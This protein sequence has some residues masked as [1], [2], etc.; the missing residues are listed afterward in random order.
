M[1]SISRNRPNGATYSPGT[2]IVYSKYEKLMLE[3]VMW[4]YA[5]QELHDAMAGKLRAVFPT[6][7]TQAEKWRQTFIRAYFSLEGEYS[8]AG[9][10]LKRHVYYVSKEA[11]LS[12]RFEGRPIWKMSN[13]P[14]G[15]PYG[16]TNKNSVA[17]RK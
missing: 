12:A 5:T 4:H 14:K 3:S 1:C 9:I 6:R 17:G 7:D 15:Y 10:A 2:R 8:L 13:D 11:D 16:K